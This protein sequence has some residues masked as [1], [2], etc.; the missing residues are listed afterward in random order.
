MREPLGKLTGRGRVI[1][2]SKPVGSISY[3]IDVWHDNPP[4]GRQGADGWAEGDLAVLQ[5]V[6]DA[7]SATLELQYGNTVSFR[8]T[9][10]FGARAEIAVSGPVPGFRH[11]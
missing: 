1:V 9:R 7:D 3:W 11:G 5:A 4:H 10:L 8:I 2:H 6:F